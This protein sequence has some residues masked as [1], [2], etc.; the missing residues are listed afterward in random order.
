MVSTKDFDAI[1]IPFV[2]TCNPCVV[3]LLTTALMDTVSVD[4]P[5]QCGHVLHPEVYMEYIS[6]PH[7]TMAWDFHCMERINRMYKPFPMPYII[8]Y[9]VVS[10][11]DMPFPVNEH[12]K[13]IQNDCFDGPQLWK[14]DIIVAKYKDT[15]Y[16]Q[17]TMASMADYPLIKIFLSSCGA[18]S[19]K[20]VPI[21][22]AQSSHTNPSSVTWDAG[23]EAVPVHAGNSFLPPAHAFTQSMYLHRLGG[24]VDNI[25]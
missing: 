11:D 19:P 4:P 15:T 12:I 24:I 9:P 18:P 2:A 13:T 17:M 20:F 14:G 22:L 7:G 16:S 23:C 6:G 1:L 25:L 3:A 10:R 21:S 5:F 8:F